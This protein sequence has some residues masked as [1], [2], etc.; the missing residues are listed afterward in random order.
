M[1]T[2]HPECDIN[3]QKSVA[4]NNNS[5][6]VLHWSTSTLP[7]AVLKHP[8]ININAVNSAGDSIIDYAIK[9]IEKLEEVTIIIIS[10]LRSITIQILKLNYGPVLV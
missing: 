3:I 10:S 1:W 5:G 7:L 2:D 9:N 4:E 6:H 8:K